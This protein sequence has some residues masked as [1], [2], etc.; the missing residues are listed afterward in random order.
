MNAFDVRFKVGVSDDTA[1][2]T[3][4]INYHLVPGDTLVYTSAHDFVVD[5]LSNILEVWAS[6]IIPNDKNDD[7][8]TKHV[9]LCTNVSIDDYETENGVY[10]GQ[11]EPNPAVMSTRIPY[12]VPEPGQVSL[13]VTNGAGQV[14]YTTKQEADL[15]TNYIE[16]NTSNFAAG[17]YYYTL[18]YKDVV[19][20]KKMV[21]NR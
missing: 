19:L 2:V 18:Y 16:L 21:I 8:N 11:N 13:E 15:G 17:V 10:L 12:A 1:S 6:V 14:L 5:Q 20:T 7:N 9:R 4:H 3:E